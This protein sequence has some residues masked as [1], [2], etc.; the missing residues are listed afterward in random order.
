MCTE[1]S[2]G[3]GCDPHFIAREQIVEDGLQLKRMVAS[4]GSKPKGGYVN[5]MVK[6]EKHRKQ[7][8]TLTKEEHRNR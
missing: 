4:R 8:H 5:W 2:K 7:G 3:G 6:E 1:H